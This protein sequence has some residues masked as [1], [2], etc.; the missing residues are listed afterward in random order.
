MISTIIYSLKDA[1]E[2][3]RLSGTTYVR[4]NILV[5]SW[6]VMVAVGQLC[7]TV[8]IQASAGIEMFAISL[9]FFIKAFKGLTDQKNENAEK[10]IT[11]DEQ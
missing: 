11:P 3:D 9:P 5:G 1:A 7:Q 8:G 2:R 6:A 10:G 4:L